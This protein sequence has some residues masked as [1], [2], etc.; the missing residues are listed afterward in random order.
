MAT[1]AESINKSKMA[2]FDLLI[3]VASD[4]S[5]F[6]HFSEPRVVGCYSLDANRSFSDGP[7]LLK[8]CE[9]FEGTKQVNFNLDEACTKS[10]ETVDLIQS[11]ERLRREENS[12]LKHVRRWINLHQGIFLAR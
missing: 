7:E 12:Q 6:P 11:R 1:H 4:Q 10:V 5:L 2:E 3:P 9:L 8:Y